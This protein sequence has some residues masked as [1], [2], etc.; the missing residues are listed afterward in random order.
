[1]SILIR[2]LKVHS[3]F[4]MRVGHEITYIHKHLVEILFFRNVMSSS[5]LPQRRRT[6]QKSELPPGEHTKHC[7]AAMFCMFP[8]SKSE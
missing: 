1:M 6:V 7:S 4:L 8:D 5:D 2:M 3:R